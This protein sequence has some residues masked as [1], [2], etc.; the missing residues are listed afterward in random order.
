[1]MW[2]VHLSK[3]MLHRTDLFRICFPFVQWRVKI[4]V[5]Y[6]RWRVRSS[7]L[8]NW[9][10]TY[11]ANFFITHEKLPALVL[12]SDRWID[13]RML[14]HCISRPRLNVHICFDSFFFNSFYNPWY[15]FESFQFTFRNKC[16]RFNLAQNKHPKAQFAQ[17]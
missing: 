12:N 6:A 13:R 10:R 15:H 5:F 16:S 4:R 14:F 2:Y 9:R 17:T 8:K 11:I 3:R 1:M 7:Y